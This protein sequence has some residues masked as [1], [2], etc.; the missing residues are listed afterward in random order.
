V[1]DRS[2][3]GTGWTLCLHAGKTAVTTASMV[4]L[5]PAD[6]SLPARAWVA[7]GSPCV[8]VYVPVPV[9]ASASGHAARAAAPPGL[10]PL[11]SDP[12]VWHRFEAVR[13]AVGTDAELLGAVRRPLSVLEDA[14]WDE[15]DALGT[16]PEAWET[17]GARAST[18]VEAA[19]DA[20]AESG[21][22]RPAGVGGTQKGD[23]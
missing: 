8:S 20:L 9:P 18:G 23:R 16:D 5:I 4:A 3:D 2:T 14:L 7:L 11:V 12:R 22:G 15:A 13:D 10:P 17:F 6:R 21:I 1:D 19:L